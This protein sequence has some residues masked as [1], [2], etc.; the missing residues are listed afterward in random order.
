MR[1]KLF[2]YEAKES[3][4]FG[5]L[6]TWEGEDI[7]QTLEHAYKKIDEES[8][9]EFYAPKLEEGVY[10]CVKGTHRL[11]DLVPFET[12]EITGVKGHK[13]ILFHAGNYNDDSSGCVLLG[14]KR[15]EDMLIRSKKTFTKF[16]SMLK[17]VNEFYLEVL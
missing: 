14:E 10:L 8:G 1:L 7:G 12:F 13:G 9:N 6:S 2:R 3:G 15:V 17:D 4:V 11:A 5:E 16:M